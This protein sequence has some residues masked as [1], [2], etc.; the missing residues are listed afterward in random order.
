M[1]YKKN[2]LMAA[3][4]FAAAAPLISLAAGMQ[5][6]PAKLEIPARAQQA[7]TA[8]V[9]VVNPTAD[10]QVFS[11]YPDDFSENIKINPSSFTL[12]AGARK[13]LTISVTPGKNQD[14]LILKTN[15]SLVSRPLTEADF[16]LATG[17]KIPLVITVT[18]APA[19]SPIGKKNILAIT[20]G[21]FVLLLTAY[22][23]NKK[24]KNK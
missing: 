16:S 21:V 3:V 10:V 22:L 15:L 5:V 9:V 12:E 2:I 6:S 1:K 17:A 7:A 13:S 4:A 19:P 24:R 20:T 18:S 8:Q 23:L 14:N 11:A